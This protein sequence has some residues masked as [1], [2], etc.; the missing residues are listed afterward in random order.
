MTTIPEGWTVNTDYGCV[1]LC[2]PPKPENPKKYTLFRGDDGIVCLVIV[3]PL[4]PHQ[5]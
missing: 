1:M 2:P 4:W 3:E 5:T